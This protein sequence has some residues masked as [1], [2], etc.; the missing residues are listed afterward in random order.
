MAFF[1]DQLE[2]IFKNEGLKGICF[3]SFFFKN[4]G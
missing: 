3:A 1:M 4:A 2:L